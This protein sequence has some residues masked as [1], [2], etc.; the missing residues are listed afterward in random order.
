MPKVSVIIPT[1]NR[2]RFVTNAIESVLNQSFRDYEIIVVDDGSTDDTRKILNEYR[3]KVRYIYQE[4][5]G[6]SAARNTG[7]KEASGKWLTFLDS[8]D[9]WRKD[10]LLAQTERINK[11]PDAI[12]HMTNVVI[13]SLEG[14]RINH[15]ASN[16]F[17]EKFK[18]KEYLTFKRPLCVVLKY[19]LWWLQSAMLRKDILLQSGLFDAHLS[20]SEDLDLIARL[21]LKGPFTISKRELVE[22]IRREEIIENL[23]AKGIRDN[24]YRYTCFSKVYSSLLDSKD[25]SRLEKITI[26]RTLSDNWRAL[27][28]ALIVAGERLEARSFYKKALLRY[29]SA[30]S[31]IKYIGTFLPQ[32]VS[33]ALVLKG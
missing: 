24:I 5:S 13:V 11:F 1:Y 22:I 25:L 7:V 30:R 9:E 32:S 17:L 29:P 4:N 15:Y 10:Y 3:G 27:G 28:N 16:N 20:I 33:R 18:D 23:W 26:R 21:S 2:E 19:G 8:D 31:L 12:G 14:K 6:V